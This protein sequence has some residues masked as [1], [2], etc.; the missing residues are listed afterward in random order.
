MHACPRGIAR[1]ITQ[2]LSKI[3]DA[4]HRSNILCD[5]IDEA[6]TVAARCALI[7]LLTVAGGPRALAT[8]RSAST[9]PDAQI[10]DTAV[11]TLAGWRDATA[12]DG[13]LEIYRQPKSEPH[14]VL[15]LRGLVRLATAENASPTPAL[16]ARYRQLLDGAR[17][18][19]DRRLLLGALAGV[20]HP[21]ALPLVLP[22][23]SNDAVHAE[24]VLAV[25]KIATAI[26]AQHPKIAQDALQ[27]V[28]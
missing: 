8:L 23:V 17:G 13:L 15:A 28:K 10:A 19:N 11:R 2:T 9:N 16:V 3:D 7:R 20:A 18:D 1:G 22:L 5:Q 21:D 27:R 26:K 4:G 6:K 24:A 12:W 14:R 25:K